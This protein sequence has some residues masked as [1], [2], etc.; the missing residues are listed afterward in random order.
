M[1]LNSKNIKR[2]LLVIFFGSVIFLSVQNLGGVL[3]FLK[4]LLSIFAPIIAALCIAFVLNVLLTALETK[5]FKF[6][7]NSAKNWV[8]KLRRPIC[9]VFTYIIAFG[10]V[11]AAILVI[12]PDIINTITYLADRL[13]SFVTE[14]RD[15]LEAVLKNLNIKNSGISDFKI[16]WATVGS[17]LKELASNYSTKFFGGAVNVTASV[18]SGLFD[19][20]FSIV[21]SVYILAQKE[22]IGAFAKRTLNALLPNKG[23]NLTLHI[24]E[25]ASFFFSKF[26]GG[27]L[28]EALLLGILCFIGMS[29]FRFPNALIISVFI[30][31]TSLVP[32]VGPI[33]GAIVGFLLIVI[34][35]PLKAVFFIIF[36]LVLQQLEG[37]LIYPR[38]VGKAVGLPGVIIVSAV[39]VG[40]NIGGVLGT[41]VAVPTSAV[42][43]TLI[44]EY[45][46]YREK[47]K[48]IEKN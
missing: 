39:L 5:V 12:I 22:R 46:E 17:A 16:N 7:G 19:G 1:E 34:T 4:K 43:F 36:F 32:I 35:N 13:P 44:K 31:F 21:I 3:G 2:L 28:I 37:N 6:M 25:R 40:G 18:F 48:R 45:T 10:I 42:L 8:R 11:S 27:Q 33:I 38:V 47:K 20:L 23:A 24:S 9:L 30:G 14:A 41:L 26:I 15:W 29:I